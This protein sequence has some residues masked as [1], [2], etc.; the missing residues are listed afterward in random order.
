MDERELRESISRVKSGRLSRREFTRMLAGLG[1][2]APMAAQLLATAGIPR[3]ASAQTKPA[4]TPTRRGGGGEL[5]TLWNL[6][7]WYREV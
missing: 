4:F 5:R 2:A 7:H 1:V 3:R 6:A